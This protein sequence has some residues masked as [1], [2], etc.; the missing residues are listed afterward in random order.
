MLSLLVEF[1]ASAEIGF[2]SV[3]FLPSSCCLALSKIKVS[4]VGLD[5]HVSA[6]LLELHGVLLPLV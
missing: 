1:F 2:P 5:V 4:Y 3:F 6:L